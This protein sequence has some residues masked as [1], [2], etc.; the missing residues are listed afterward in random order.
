MKT[1]ESSILNR[2]NYGYNDLE[3]LVLGLMALNRNFMIVGRH[4]IGKTRLVQNLSRG[5]SESGFAFYDAT[6]DDLISIAGIPNPEAMKQGELRFL[7]HERTIWNKTSIV[8]DEITRA[9]K[10]NQNMWLEILEQKTC[11]G[12]PLIYQ[13]L[14]ATANPESYA[15]A[16]RLDEALLD[17]FYAVINAPEHQTDIT[18]DGIAEMMDLHFAPSSHEDFSEEMVVAFSNIRL[19]YKKIRQSSHTMKKLTDYCASFSNHLLN[20]QRQKN[21]PVYISPRTYSRNFPE[22]VLAVAAYYKWQG[23]K[24]Y[25]C[26]SAEMAWKFALG[27]KLIID[28]AELNTIHEAFKPLLE[29]EEMDEIQTI[30]VDLSQLSTIEERMAYIK[31]HALLI[32]EKLPADEIEKTLGSLLTEIKETSDTDKLVDLSAIVRLIEKGHEELSRRINGKLLFSL[33]LAIAKVSPFFHHLITSSSME[34]KHDREIKTKLETFFKISSEVENLAYKKS[35]LNPL[36]R[37]ILDAHGSDKDLSEERVIEVLDKIPL[38]A[39]LD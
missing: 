10:E 2:I 28:P 17:R 26:K 5:L 27:T 1:D 21:D 18:R 7:Q 24:D 9:S 33:T 23:H 11:F 12:L 39:F 35:G 15:A 22:V 4:G 38:K 14:I 34:S 25:L 20:L 29:G 30:R 16:N 36:K 37:F 3:P 8:V 6:K 31:N 19:E 13:S 32:A